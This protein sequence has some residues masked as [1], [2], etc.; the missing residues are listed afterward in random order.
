MPC[1]VLVLLIAVLFFFYPRSLRA[2]FSLSGPE[3][4]QSTYLCSVL[5]NLYLLHLDL[6]SRICLLSLCLKVKQLFV[7]CVCCSRCCLW[8]SLIPT[9]SQRKQK[10]YDCYNCLTGHAQW[11]S[12][13]RNSVLSSIRSQAKKLQHWGLQKKKNPSC[14]MLLNSCCTG[15][16]E[17]ITSFQQCDVGSRVLRYERTS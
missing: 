17:R 6:S 3:C 16:S 5:C 14:R 8:L 9:C 12:G 4:I 1:I 11:H 2:V 13:A 10:Q 7:Y 15:I